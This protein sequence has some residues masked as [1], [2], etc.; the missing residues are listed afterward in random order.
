MSFLSFL[1]TTVFAAETILSPLTVDRIPYYTTIPTPIVSFG[2]LLP[3]PSQVLGGSDISPQP[4]IRTPVR[5]QKKN[6][7]IVLL[8]DSMVDTLGPE[9]PELSSELSSRFSDA[10]FTILN[11][12]AGGTNID[13]GIERLTNDHEYLGEQRP[14]LITRLPDIVVIES[15]AYN[16]YPY[17]EGALDRHWLALAQTIDT[18]KTHVPDARIII[19]ATI[20]PNA[21]VFG[22]GAKDTWFSPVDKYERVGTI[23]KYLESTTRFAQSQNLPLADAYHPSLGSDGN[24]KVDYINAG[25]HIHYSPAGRAFFAKILT[26]TIVNNKILE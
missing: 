19:A 15:F 9:F 26:G 17:D 16:P 13:Y 11:Y 14:A 10:S 6:Y 18:L 20:A 25:D 21:T 3:Q 2:D 22:D 12:G 7:T 1:A 23:K 24:G 4:E 8:G 5:L